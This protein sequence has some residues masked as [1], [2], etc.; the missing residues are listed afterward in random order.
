M[1]LFACISSPPHSL[2]GP[3]MFRH[4]L[5]PT[6][7]SKLSQQAIAA[8]VRLARNLDATVVGVHVSPPHHGHTPEELMH[9]QA[10]VHRRREELLDRQA[11]EY[12]AYVANSALA[13]E[14]PCVCKKLRLDD[15]AQGIVDTA[16]KMRCDLIY[17]AS[18]GWG[19][20]PETVIGS[21]TIRVL[22]LSKVP[23]LVY[24]PPQVADRGVSFT[25]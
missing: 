5:L 19:A 4:I 22:H 11:E 20:D 12:L 9:R 21:E 13:D 2:L 8:G 1:T 15:P 6:D 14:V 7:G 17:M 18:H 25:A 10:D 23:V 3:D 24:K 16:E